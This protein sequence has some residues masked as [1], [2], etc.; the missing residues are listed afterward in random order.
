MRRFLALAIVLLLLPT[1]VLSAQREDSNMK[2]VTREVN[3]TSDQR[4]IQVLREHMRTMVLFRRLFMV[5][6]V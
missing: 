5:F 2:E 6:K 3:R 1:F 4:N